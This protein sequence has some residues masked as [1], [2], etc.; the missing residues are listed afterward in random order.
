MEFIYKPRAAKAILK[1]AAYVESKNTEGSGV[2]WFEKLDDRIISVAETK[3]GLAK[4]RHHTLAK[5]NYRCFEFK[6]WIIAYKI[7][8][9]T[10]EICRFI[11]AARLS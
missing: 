8:G 4:C 3:Y 1:V 5:F 9:N 7:N 11:W 2:R 6:G 10:F